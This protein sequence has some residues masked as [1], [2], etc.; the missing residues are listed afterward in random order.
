MIRRFLAVP[1][2]LM[3]GLALP[4]LAQDAEGFGAADRAAI[5]DVI[6]AQLAAFRND[7]GEAAF[8][9]AS[10]DIQQ[11]FGDPTRFLAMVKSG[12]MPVYRPRE[13]RFRELVSHRGEP[14][15]SVL[16]VG[17]DFDVVT[18]FYAMQRQPDGTWR[19]N[20]C[21]LKPAADQAL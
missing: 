14:V 18:A 5:R 2:L 13:V 11:M 17:P 19:I 4:A 7:D 12:Y 21:V 10:P 15:Q 20:G 16:V 3:L 1:V 9:F 8:G 6:E